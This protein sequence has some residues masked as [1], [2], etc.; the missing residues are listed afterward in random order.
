MY[1]YIQERRQRYERSQEIL[2]YNRRSM[3]YLLY[4]LRSAAA[5]TNLETSGLKQWQQSE[6]LRAKIRTASFKGPSQRHKKSKHSSLES[7]TKA[8]RP[9]DQQTAAHPVFS[10]RT[11]NR[12]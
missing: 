2:R 9:N 5:T 12:L 1:D 4:T 6:K 8:T 7:P 11:H 3:N 10:T